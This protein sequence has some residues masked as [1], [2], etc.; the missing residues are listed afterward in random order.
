M[1][2][3]TQDLPRH[4]AVIMDGNGRWAARRGLP[5][6]DGHR[7]G[8]E[9]ARAAA[10]CCLEWGIPVLTLYAFSTENWKRPA[11]EVRFLMSNLRS[12]L[13]KHRADFIENNIRLRVIGAPSELPA[14]VQKELALTLEAT[15]A[16]DGLTLVLALNYGS[17]REIT[18]AARALARKALSGTLDPEDIDEATLE[19]HLYTAGLPPLDLVIRTG[20]EMRLSNFLLWQV[21][22]AELYVTDTLWPDFDEA[23]FRKALEEFARRERR[24]GAVREEERVAP[25]HRS[26]GA[27][28]RPTAR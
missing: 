16:C 20:G 25:T 9:A 27:R 1:T 18:E 21:Q 22:Y 15:A 7:A 12:F 19:E 6:T 24:W 3:R 2:E 26:G 17:H 4:V 28:P 8:A 5:R 14:G 23:Q 10:Q 13:R 11:A